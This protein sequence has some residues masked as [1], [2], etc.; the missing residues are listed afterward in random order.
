MN[1]LTKIFFEIIY[2]MYIVHPVT[3]YYDNCEI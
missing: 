2:E 3:I 1:I